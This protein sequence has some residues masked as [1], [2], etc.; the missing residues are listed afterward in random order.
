[1]SRQ[2][3]PSDWM[4]HLGQEFE[5][6]YM[7]ELSLFL[8]QEKSSGKIIYP[9]GG[10]IF[11]AFHLTPFSSV[12]VIILG[13]DPYHGVNQAHGLSF[14]VKKGVRPPPSLINI[15]QELKEDLR[16]DPPQHGDLTKWAQ[17][18]VLLLNTVLTVE[19]SKAGSHQGKGWET[20][21]DKVITTLSEKK[22]NLVFILWG[23]PAQKKMSLIDSNKHLIIKSPHPSPY[24][25]DRG[26]FGS[27][28]FSNTNGFLRSKNISEINWNLNAL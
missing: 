7:K 22:E 15:F 14:S 24:S 13:Q 5:S 26:F 23:S 12:K 1:M 28:P 8:K 6:A 4:E 3:L 25:A 16:I 10:E 27:K 11:N 20:F 2:P 18:G 19:K 21:T 17:E 9:L